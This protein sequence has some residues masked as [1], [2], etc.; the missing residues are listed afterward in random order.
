MYSRERGCL[1]VAGYLRKKRHN[2]Q[3]SMSPTRLGVAGSIP[4]FFR[5]NSATSNA[6]GGSQTCVVVY[7]RPPYFP[8][9][10]KCEKEP[11]AA[12]VQHA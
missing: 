12:G 2:V 1:K 10:R 9:S 5:A 3:L 4:L 8:R 7:P 11:S 6:G